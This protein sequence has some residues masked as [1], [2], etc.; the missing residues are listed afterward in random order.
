[1]DDTEDKLY[2]YRA[3]VVD[4]GARRGENQALAPTLTCGRSQNG[5]KEGTE[6]NNKNQRYE[7]YCSILINLEQLTK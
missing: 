7:K 3:L 4:M 6:C 2:V 1:L 5:R